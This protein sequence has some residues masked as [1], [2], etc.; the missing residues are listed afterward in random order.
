LYTS[1]KYTVSSVNS[2]SIPL[3]CNEFQGWVSAEP[4]IIKNK[5]VMNSTIA[6]LMNTIRHSATEV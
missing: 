1:S 5:L 3:F 2:V 6:P 4:N